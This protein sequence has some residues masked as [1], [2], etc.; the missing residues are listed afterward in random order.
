MAN[1]C[2]RKSESINFMQ[3]FLDVLTSWNQFL[4]FFILMNTVFIYLPTI[5]LEIFHH[6]FL[7]LPCL[8]LSLMKYLSSLSKISH[9]NLIF[10]FFSPSSSSSSSSSNAG[11]LHQEFLD[12]LLTTLSDISSEWKNK[13]SCVMCYL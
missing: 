7:W 8:S 4:F 5:C 13:Q 11:P 10:P 2:W 12:K 9:W 1:A 6:Q 3:L